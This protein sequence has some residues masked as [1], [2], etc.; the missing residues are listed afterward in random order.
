MT[1]EL[2]ESTNNLAHDVIAAAMQVS[3]VLGSGFLEKV[4]ERA[5]VKELHG[6]GIAS[7]SQAPIEVLYKGESVGEFYADVL[8]ANC[9]IVELKCVER[10]SSEHLAQCINYLKAT[11][12]PLALLINF[13]HPRLE[14]KRVVMTRDQSR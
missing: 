3:N 8:V 6:R 5:L 9:L 14:W 4:Y 2:D 7:T 12:H 10:L 13:Q 11:G 1:R